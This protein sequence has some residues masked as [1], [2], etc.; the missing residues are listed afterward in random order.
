[1]KTRISIKVGIHE[2]RGMAPTMAKAIAIVEG[3][4]GENVFTEETDA[5]CVAARAHAFGAI[6]SLE[7]V[8]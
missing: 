6:W 4:T 2:F 8:P 1:M 5:E 7:V 3:I